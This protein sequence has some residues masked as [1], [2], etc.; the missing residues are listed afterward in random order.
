MKTTHRNTRNTP[1]PREKKGGIPIHTKK[2]KPSRILV[3]LNPFSHVSISEVECRPATYTIREMIRSRTAKYRNRI[4]KDNAPRNSKSNANKSPCLNSTGSFGLFR[5]FWF[6]V[7]SRIFFK[8]AFYFVHLIH[9]TPS[10]T[11]VSWL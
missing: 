3:R 6:Y 11:Q 9:H 5:T 8:I 10:F 1:Q 7:F 2:H 4:L